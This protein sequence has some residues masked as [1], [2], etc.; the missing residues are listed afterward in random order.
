MHGLRL[1]P[2]YGPRLWPSEHSKAMRLRF[3]ELFDRCERVRAAK[4]VLVVIQA[5]LDSARLNSELSFEG[6]D[7]AFRDGGFAQL[8]KGVLGEILE[9]DAVGVG[10]QGRGRQIER[11]EH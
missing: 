6:F 3:P 5:L 8:R 10:V 4:P 1:W 7:L 9:C 2:M 11:H